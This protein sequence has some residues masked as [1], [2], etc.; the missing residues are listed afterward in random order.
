MTL[1]DSADK[2]SVIKRVDGA[3]ES[4]VLEDIR[5]MFHFFNFPYYFHRSCENHYCTDC[6]LKSD[7]K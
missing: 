6:L 1:E 2:D 3:I 7:D 5:S 4:I